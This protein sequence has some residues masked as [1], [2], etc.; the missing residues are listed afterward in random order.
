MTVS[1]SIY[2][3]I[4]V[5]PCSTS[6]TDSELDFVIRQRVHFCSQHED[7]RHLHRT[8]AE[9]GL[10]KDMLE[11]FRNAPDLTSHP[12]C[13]APT[14]SGFGDTSSEITDQFYDHLHQIPMDGLR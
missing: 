14:S 8:R 13:R 11:R 3:R 2:Q 12:S 1:S 6:I 10:L 9:F 4:I 7:T 5:L